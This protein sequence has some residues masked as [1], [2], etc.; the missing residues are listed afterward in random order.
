[1]KLPSKISLN[2][3][4]LAVLAALTGA[5]C[6]GSTYAHAII[7]ITIDENGNGIGTAGSGILQADP[8]PGG[9]PSV[10]TYALKFTTV[11]GDVLLTDGESVLD[12]LRFN[13]NTLLFYSDNIDGFDT[14]GDTAGPPRAQYTNVISIPE[15]GTEGNNGAFYTPLRRQPGYMSSDFT[16]TYHFISDAPVPEPATIALFGLGLAGLFS[17]AGLKRSVS[18]AGLRKN[19]RR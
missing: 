5:I 2:A 4:A 12:V 18:Y 9:L 13:G 6:C 10:L 7:T 8:G 16:V 11:Q 17:V 3:K 19:P 15:L 14:L 1:M